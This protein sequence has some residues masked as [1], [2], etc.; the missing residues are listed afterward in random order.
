MMKKTTRLLAMILCLVMCFSLVACG[1]DKDDA[2]ADDKPAASDK[3]ADKPADDGK[4]E[5]PK[6]GDITPYFVMPVVL[7]SVCAAAAYVTIKRK[8]AR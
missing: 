6:N 8:N 1:G 3:P 5:E 4:D 2:K 7:V